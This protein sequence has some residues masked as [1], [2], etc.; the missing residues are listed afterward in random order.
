MSKTR[1]VVYMLVYGMVRGVV[2]GS[3]C[4]GIVYGVIFAT[5]SGIILPAYF[6]L[7]AL[8]GIMIGAILGVSAG[9]ISGL[10][11]GITTTLISFQTQLQ[12]KQFA[13]VSSILLSV[14]CNFFISVIIFATQT[15]KTDLTIHRV[16]S[17]IVCPLFTADLSFR[18]SRHLTSWYLSNHSESMGY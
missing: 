18:I 4:W 10:S 6:L 12:Y 17:M 9:F 7:G 13:L 11:T 8:Y 2:F 1:I 16:L 3:L 5:G 14:F 15:H